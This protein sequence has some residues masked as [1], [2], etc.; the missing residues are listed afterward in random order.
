MV[1][2][3]ITSFLLLA[4]ISYAIYCWQRTSS[5][6]NAGHALPPPPPRFRG[7]F[8]DEHSDAQLAAR[9]REAEALKR[10]SEQRVGLLER[11][12][13]GDKA[14]LRE[15]HAIGDTALYDEVL[16]ALVLRA[17]DNYKQLFAL[18][19]H[20]TRSD[21]LRANAPLA[22]RFLE[23][24]KTSPERRSVAVVLHIAARADDAPLY[25]RAVETAHQFWLDGL[26]HGV[27]AEELRAIFDG[28]YWLLSQ[29]V[30]GSGEGFVLKRKLAKLRQELS[31]ASS[32][33]V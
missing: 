2:V 28:E 23:V 15:A 22:E 1:T 20:I 31:R 25:Q 9:L 21:Q 19:S 17:E 32:K 6:E 8:N 14:V 30:R 27:S 26:L 29:S 13:Q 10:T 7:L 16:S 24:W 12:T 5:N 4:A 11:A 18:V 3:L 33:T